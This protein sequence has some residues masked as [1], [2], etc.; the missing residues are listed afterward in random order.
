MPNT[1]TTR[2]R[3]FARIAV[4]A[5][6]ECWPWL[7]TADRD[8]YG[9][10]SVE[11][12]G[13]RYQRAHRAAWYFTNGHVPHGAMVCHRCDNPICCNPAHLFLGTAADNNADMIS[14]GRARYVGRGQSRFAVPRGDNHYL[15]RHPEAR[16]F[17]ADHHMTKVSD[18][19]VR[20]MRAV[21]AA[22]GVTFEQLGARYGI[23]KGHAHAIVR[24]RF[25]QH[26]TSASSEA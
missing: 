14:K 3:F 10:V 26:A 13:H 15:R 4:G 18:E 16:R 7:G 11:H 5:P 17:D 6:D 12:D 25:R 2:E 19:Q 24:G 8:G 23:S 21:Y 9:T 22:G 1:R 20:E